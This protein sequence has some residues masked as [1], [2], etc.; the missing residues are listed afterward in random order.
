[1]QSISFM[2]GKINYTINQ[3]VNMTHRISYCLVLFCITIKAILA[4]DLTPEDLKNLFHEHQIVPDVIAKTP[5]NLLEVSYAN[6]DYVKPGSTLDINQV[7]EKPSLKWK[8]TDSKS[9]YTLY[10]VNP[11]VPSRDEPLEAEWQ[12]WT[13]HNIPGDQLERYS[14]LFLKSRY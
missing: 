12:H 8:N 1:M 13:V 4:Y 2:K 7:L 14:N 10:L 11:D 3:N 6:Q 9:L 5:D